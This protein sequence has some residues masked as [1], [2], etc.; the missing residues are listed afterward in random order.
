MRLLSEIKLR[1]LWLSLPLRSFAPHN[2]ILFLTRICFGR[3]LRNAPK[4]LRF[5][6]NIAAG[7]PKGA[8]ACAPDFDIIPASVIGSPSATKSQP[9]TS[10]SQSVKCECNA[11]SAEHS[12]ER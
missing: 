2:R 10:S 6:G 3:P 8:Q 1:R 7:D 11:Q 9:K 4:K 12:A 5:E